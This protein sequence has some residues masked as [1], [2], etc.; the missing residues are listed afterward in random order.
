[1]AKSFK[2]LVPGIKRS[3]L[4]LEKALICNSI[5]ITLAPEVRRLPDCESILPVSLFA[6]LG[7]V[8]ET[9]RWIFDVLLRLQPDANVKKFLF[10]HRLWAEIS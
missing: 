10:R 1:M 9:V 2:T 7:L 5:F 8:L 4:T 6:K 3:I